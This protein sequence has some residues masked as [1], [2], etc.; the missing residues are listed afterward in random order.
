[1]NKSDVRSQ[2]KGKEKKKTKTKK[3]RCRMYDFLQPLPLKPSLCL[4]VD[5]DFLQAINTPKKRRE[6]KSDHKLKDIA[7]NHIQDSSLASILLMLVTEV[8][9]KKERGIREVELKGENGV[10]VR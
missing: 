7:L 10:C 6:K 1:M 5:L 2:K 3:S 9:R 4:C 8:K